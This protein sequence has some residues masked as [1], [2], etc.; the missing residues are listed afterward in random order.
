M[1]EKTGISTIIPR[2]KAEHGKLHGNLGVIDVIFTV[3]AYNGPAV[4]FMA[5]LPVLV[6]WGNGVGA[7]AMILA[8][9]VLITIVATGLINVSQAMK[10]PGGFYSLISASLGRIPGLGAG[11]AALFTYFAALVSVYV[12]AGTALSDLVVQFLGGTEVPWWITGLGCVVVISVL[13][14]FNIRLS[15]KVLYVFL[16]LEFVLIVVYIIAVAAQ[17]GANGFGFESFTPEYMFSGSLA[18]GALFAITI[19]GGFEATVIFREEVRDPDKTIKRA[20]YGVIALLAGCYA[21]LAWV[22][23]NAYGPDVILEVLEG[24]LTG[25][26]GDSVRNYVGETAYLFANIL[27]FTSALALQLASHNILTRYVYNFG[28]DGILPKAMAHT[29]ERHVSPYKA[30]LG[31]SAFAVVGVITLAFAPIDT[32]I[33]YAT[34]ASFITYGMII[35]VTLVSVGIGIYMLMNRTS[36]LFHAILMFAAGGIFAT[37]LIFAS[38]RF[39]L[40]S[41]LVGA[42]A[43]I[44]LAVCWAF[45]LSGMGLALSHK[46]KRPEIYA[47]IGRRE[48]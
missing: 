26:A 33:L 8:I 24:N 17:G 3:V 14:Y 44:I 25:A 21:T 13:G 35:L 41:G 47:R 43:V 6:L 39:D 22:F 37:A 34:I 46:H 11:F 18:V 32:G 27:L 42:P 20:T 19:F 38:V 16:G 28:V 2:D 29:H 5:F 10:R 45:I 7:P 12:V 48:D 15:A 1:T 4:V 30:S 9:G 23:I 36:S 31:V 40:L